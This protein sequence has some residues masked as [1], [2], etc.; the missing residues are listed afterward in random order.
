MNDH[1]YRVRELPPELE[2]LADLATDLRWTWSHAGELNMMPS[3]RS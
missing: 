3:E 1:S 2:I